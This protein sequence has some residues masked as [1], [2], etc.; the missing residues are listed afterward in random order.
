MGGQY[1]RG[2]N[3]AR[4]RSPT[5]LGDQLEAL[6]AEVTVKREHRGHAQTPHGLEAGTVDE[7]EFFPPCDDQSQYTG[8]VTL[9]I[10]PLYADEGENVLMKRPDGHHAQ[11]VLDRAKVSTMT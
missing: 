11:A 5:G 3:T 1:P 2:A 9:G 10:H 4:R 8:I 7:A 6:L